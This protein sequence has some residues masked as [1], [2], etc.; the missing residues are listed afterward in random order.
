M[1]LASKVKIEID[2]KEAKDFLH[3]TIN[4]SIYGLNKFEVCF[5]LDTFESTEG[6]VLE[7]TKLAIGATI[8]I[9]IDVSQKGDGTAPDTFIF[10]GIITNLRGLKSGL[11]Q[12][13]HILVSGESPE[14]LLQDIKGSRSFE[15]KNL[16]QI[17]DE[18]LKPFPVDILKSKVNPSTKVQFEYAVQYNENN[19]EFLRRLASRH[20]EWMF[21]DGTEFIFG[22]LSSSKT[23]M[24]LGI[25]Q[26]EFDFGINLN[27]LN[28]NYKFYDYYTKTTLENK[29]TKSVGKK[30]LN[31]VGKLAHDKSAKHFSYQSQAYY[32]HLNVAKGNYY[33][34]LKDIVELKENAKAVGMS[35][36]EGSSQNAS[37]KLGGKVNIKALKMDMKGK[38]DYGEYMITSVTHTCDNLMNYNNK[39]KGVSAEATVPDYTN[40]WAIAKSEAQSAVVVDNKDPEKLGRVR[41]NFFW[42]NSDQKSPWIRAVNP[43][44]ANERGFYFI[45]EIED[46]VLVGFEGGDAEKPYVVGSLYHGTNKPHSNWP[47]NKNNFKGIV[48]RSNLR[49]EFDEEKKTTTIDTPAGNKIVV[50]DDKQT[51][52]LSDENMNK[53]EMSPDGIVLDSM[54][55]ISITS[56]AKISIDALNGI[57]LSSTAGDIK[58]SGLNISH[59]ANIDFKAE[60]LAS[61]E[62]KNAVASL[63]GDA[64]GATVKGGPMT[65]IQGLLVK[66]N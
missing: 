61:A 25:N 59:K 28:F 26:S 56:Q 1:A 66:I 45:P 2:G 11:S 51:I 31:E 20:G 23:N 39:F 22:S 10:K 9:N 47:N 46:E 52:L 24:I 5:R 18:V 50:S 40:P 65:T 16:K 14:I 44:S 36:V 53:V 27:P 55:D 12:S 57:E 54:K 30:Q 48:T 6:F 17:V 33:K 4:Q 62:L 63:K 37:V 38:V 29:S 7:K 41:V 42:Q 21:Y 43:Y 60:G 8:V 49:L 32:N 64:T 34:Q 3:L 19:Y 58:S 13:N 35:T 15:N